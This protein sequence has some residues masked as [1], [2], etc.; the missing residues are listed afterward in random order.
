ML[1]VW[2]LTAVAIFITVMIFKVSQIKSNAKFFVLLALAALITAS[3]TSFTFSDSFDLKTPRGI[4]TGISVYF[5]W[6]AGLLQNI[7]TITG[8][9]IGEARTTLNFNWTG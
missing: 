5:N 1:S 4:L 7:W 9:V 3:L 6:L 8:N 2:L